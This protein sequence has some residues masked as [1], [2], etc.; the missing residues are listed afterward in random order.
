MKTHGHGNSQI[1]DAAAMQ[2]HSSD[3]S[4]ALVRPHQL[5]SVSAIALAMMPRKTPGRAVSASS[6]QHAATAA[7]RAMNTR[8]P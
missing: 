4:T 6:C 3:S 8:R 1:T 5:S 7:V 2:K